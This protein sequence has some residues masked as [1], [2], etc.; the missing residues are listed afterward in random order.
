MTE[1]LQRKLAETIGAIHTAAGKASD[2]ALEHLPDIAQSYII[3]GRASETL[4]AI[5]FIAGAAIATWVAVRKGFLSSEKDG[6]GYWTGTRL[7]CCL[8]GTF[9]A[10]V[11]IRF[12]LHAASNALLVWL[13]PK[14]WLLKA[15]ATLIK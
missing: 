12:A 8:G 3:Y 11:F 1:D 10:V 5:V 9:V 13:A 15:L 7:A 2:F 4:L 14:V 6:W